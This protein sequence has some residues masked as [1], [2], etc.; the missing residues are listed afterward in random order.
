M[1]R[2]AIV[3]GVSR[4]KGIG[5]A[6]CV[7]LAKEGIDVFITFWRA[8]D[9]RNEFLPPGAFGDNEPELIQQEICD[10]GVTC[11]A[12]E[13]DLGGEK[14]AVDLFNEVE[15]R[16]GP[17]DILINN[18]TY[19]TL[20]NI[21]D[22][23]AEEL[24]NHYYVNL[25]AVTLLCSEF[26]KRFKGQENGRIVNISSGQELSAMNE[27]IAYSM[28]KSAI[29][30]LTRT[31]SHQLAYQG[32]TINAVNPGLTDSG[33][34][35]QELKDKFEERFPMGRFGTPEDAARLVAFLVSDK[36]QWVTGQIINSEGGFIREQ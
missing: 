27:E 23:T 13:L 10:L 34:I 36:A 16:L 2:I 17:A 29:N 18:A 25:R 20:T 24:D 30:T 6:L 26:V 9:R 21:D 14:S 15:R 7:E 28:T 35:S 3:T 33:W 12:L 19:S 5:R 22:I 11:E 4:L 8:Y 32:I 31:I 1:K